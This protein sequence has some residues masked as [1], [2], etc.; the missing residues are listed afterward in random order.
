L[1]RKYSNPPLKDLKHISIDELC[2]GRPRKFITLVLDLQT[3]AIVFSA[4][5]KKASV[6]KP[7]WKRLRRSRATVQAVAIDLGASYRNSVEENLPT[8]TIIWDHFHIVQLMN[9]KLTELRRQLYRQATD[10]LKKKVLKGTRWLLL[11]APEN[12]DPIKGEPARLREALNLNE[13]LSAAYYLKETLR[14]IWKQPGRHV[15]RLAIL[16]WYHQEMG[17]GVRM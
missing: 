3:G 7:F 15:S 14:E 10:D 11:T 6:M 2:V 16:D 8:A 12:V 17:S 1:K 5:G 9:R 13:S 4:E